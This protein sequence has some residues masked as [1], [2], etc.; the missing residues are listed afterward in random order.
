MNNKDIIALILAHPFINAAV[1]L[2]IQHQKCIALLMEQLEY[3]EEDAIQ[4]AEDQ[5][6][7]INDI[8][9]TFFRMKD[10]GRSIDEIA[11]TI[12]EERK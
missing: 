11:Q 10:E 3:T 6:E 8:G 7:M 2:K 1:E 4:F 9:D 5:L 12:L